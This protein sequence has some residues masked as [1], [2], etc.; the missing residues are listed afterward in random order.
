MPLNK[1]AFWWSLTAL[2]ALLILLGT[3][4]PVPGAG[5]V[6]RLPSDKLM[7]CAAFFLLSV[8]AGR[9]FAGVPASKPVVSAMLAFSCSTAYGVVTEIVQ[10]FVPGRTADVWDVG[11]DA[12]GA[13]AGA[14]ALVLFFR[15]P[16][17]ARAMKS[18]KPGLEAKGRLRAS[19]VTVCVVT[20]WAVMMGILLKDH[21]TKRAIAP[22][23]P[24]F[25]KLLPENAT[26][27]E[28]KMGIYLVGKRLGSAETKIS[29]KEDEIHMQNVITV[30]VGRIPSSIRP[31][32]KDVV[33]Y[34]DA[35]F[36]PISGLNVITISV[37]A[38]EISLMGRVKDDQMVIAGR[39]GKKR[40]AETIPF[41][42]GS[43]VSD[44]FS[45]LHGVPRLT[46][47][48]IGRKWTLTLLNPLT[49]RPHPVRIE[50]KNMLKQKIGGKET[51][52]FVLEFSSS[53]GKWNSWVTG[54]GEVLQQGTPFM[55]VLKREDIPFLS[56]GPGE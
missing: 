12:T 18:L 54:E 56:G 32:D 51:S 42:Q 23:K 46:R 36:K 48:D 9:A 39:I 20:F 15:I 34:F 21:Y 53:K 40:I 17:I 8:S 26:Q 44:F 7:H 52:V 22:L 30:N 41:S 27:I 33:I 3:C 2:T 50:V 43:L 55:L 25:D 29:R 45:P 24:T 13:M 35:H 6:A 37:E 5:M 38:L 49:A 10:K 31:F 19:A 1:P 16:G 28:R 14:F 4:M 11:A 47:S